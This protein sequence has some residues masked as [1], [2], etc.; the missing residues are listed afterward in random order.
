[1]E[2]RRQRR[3]R[4][5]LAGGAYV[6]WSDNTNWGLIKRPHPEIIIHMRTYCPAYARVF[7]F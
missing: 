1:M 6:G 4:G 2:Q 3:R 5:T 7:F